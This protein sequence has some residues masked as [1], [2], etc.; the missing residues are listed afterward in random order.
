MTYN[1][2]RDLK[3]TKTILSRIL[4]QFFSL[5][6]SFYA[7]ILANF[8]IIFTQ[9]CSLTKEW[10]TVIKDTELIKITT[11]L[12]IKLRD[13]GDQ[14][15]GFPRLLI[16]ANFFPT[17]M[18]LSSDG[19]ILLASATAHLTSVDISTLKQLKTIC[20]CHL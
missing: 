3:I 5:T 10:K 14:L 20:R 11:D 9:A 17:V 8:K 7:P 16:P 12:P 1:E 6:G 2:I 13:T 18:D 19:G 4:G 15:Q